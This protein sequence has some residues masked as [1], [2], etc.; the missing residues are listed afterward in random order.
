[1]RKQPRNKETNLKLTS[2]V[3]QGLSKF[4]LTQE[5]TN[6]LLLRNPN[7]YCQFTKAH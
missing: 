3:V 1:V 2:S 6:S 4:I 7:G 5:P